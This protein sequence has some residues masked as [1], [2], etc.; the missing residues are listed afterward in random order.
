[1]LICTSLPQSFPQGIR[2]H[3]IIIASLVLYTKRLEEGASNIQH[4]LSDDPQQPSSFDPELIIFVSSQGTETIEDVSYFDSVRESYSKGVAVVEKKIRNLEVLSSEL[5]LSHD[6][7]IRCAPACLL[8][9]PWYARETWSE[10][11]RR[12][13]RASQ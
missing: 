12:L 7:G 9:L 10:A 4:G 8:F 13:I 5:S 2:S 1:M 3:I 11:L 6:R